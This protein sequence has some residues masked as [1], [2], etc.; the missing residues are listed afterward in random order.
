MTSREQ[1]AGR[2]TF[3][4]NDFSPSIGS[5]E[6]EAQQTHHP[7][8]STTE[9]SPVASVPVHTSSL[10]GESAL[11]HNGPS[12]NRGCSWRDCPNLEWDREQSPC[13]VA[14]SPDLCLPCGWMW[15]DL[16]IF[17]LNSSHGGHTGA[18]LQKI[19][20]LHSILLSTLF[21]FKTYGST[22]LQQ[23]PPQQQNGLS[24]MEET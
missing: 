5:V 8:L 11:G 22:R 21:F 12:P 4:H 14:L 2:L 16:R 1:L 13:P 6:Q 7:H 3:S 19:I 15:G 23:M 10:P 20:P 17:F 18:K 9:R 24:I